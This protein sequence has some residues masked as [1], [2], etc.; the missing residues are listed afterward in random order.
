MD[1]RGRFIDNIFV[2]RLWRY[3]KYEEVYLNNYETVS[4]AVNGLSRYFFFYNLERP[5]GHLGYKNPYEV[6][7][8]ERLNIKPA[9]FNSTL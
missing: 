5:Y 2:K 4:D 8:K 3:V 6:Y 1:G 7:V 9:G